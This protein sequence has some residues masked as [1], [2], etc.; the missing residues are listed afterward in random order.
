MK[1]D[2]EIAVMGE[3]RAVL[4]VRGSVVLCASSR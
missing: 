4:Q 3:K 2:R 1:E